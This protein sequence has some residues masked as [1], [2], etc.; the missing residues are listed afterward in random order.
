[1]KQQAKSANF[2]KSESKHLLLT[3]FFFRKFRLNLSREEMSD[4]INGGKEWLRR[5]QEFDIITGA[6]VNERESLVFDAS[7]DV[8]LTL[9]VDVATEGVHG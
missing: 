6:S 9:S 7:T 5:I 2:F 4:Y 3:L 8:N 1:M